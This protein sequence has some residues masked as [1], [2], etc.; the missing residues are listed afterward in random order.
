MPA[1]QAASI[2]F[3]SYVQFV[4]MGFVPSVFARFDL[5]ALLSDT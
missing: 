1:T 4:D 3:V 5:A 2:Y